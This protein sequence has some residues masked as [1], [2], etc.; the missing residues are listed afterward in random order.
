MN[1]YKLADKLMNSLTM[2]YDCDD[3]MILGAELLKQQQHEIESLKTQ[4]SYLES[5]VYGGSTK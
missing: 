1:A 5:K 2:E 3:Y 4:I